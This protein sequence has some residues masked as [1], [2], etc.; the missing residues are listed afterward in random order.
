MACIAGAD[1]ADMLP[2]LTISAHS[3]SHMHVSF[4]NKASNKWTWM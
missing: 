2:T 1:R 3:K 4:V